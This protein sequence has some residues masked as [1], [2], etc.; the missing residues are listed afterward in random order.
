MPK[1]KR[2]GDSLYS[3]DFYLTETR[4]AIEV[5]SRLHTRLDAE[6]RKRQA[7]TKRELLKQSRIPCLFVWDVE[8]SHDD[9][10]PVIRKIEDFIAQAGAKG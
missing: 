4:Q 8:L 3:M 2:I 9:L 1:T 5:N 7:A 10:S 6:K